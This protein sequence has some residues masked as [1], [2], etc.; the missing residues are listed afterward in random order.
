MPG[1]SGAG[2]TGDD[3]YGAVSFDGL[4]PGDYVIQE[5]S[6]EYTP[7]LVLISCYPYGEEPSVPDDLRPWRRLPAHVRRG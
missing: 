2:T 4:D 1:T 7:R 3:G 6:A 5:T